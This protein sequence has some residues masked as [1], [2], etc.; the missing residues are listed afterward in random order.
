MLGVMTY[1]LEYTVPADDGSGDIAFP[2]SEQDSGYT[3]PLSETDAE[4][5]RSERLPVRT[6]ILGSSL[7]K[8]KA[9]A[10][11]I[12]RHSKAEAGFL[13]DDPSGSAQA[14]SGELILKY[15]QSGWEEQ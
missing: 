8:A 11:E 5:V 10:E 3:V 9:E 15:G 13:Y 12:I 4:V 1:F 7:A 6:S 14:G 2:L